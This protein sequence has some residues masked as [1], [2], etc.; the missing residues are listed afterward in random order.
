[1]SYDFSKNRCL[2]ISSIAYSDFDRQ[3]EAGKLGMLRL[4][5]LLN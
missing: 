5:K 4:N 1:M 3:H 2:K